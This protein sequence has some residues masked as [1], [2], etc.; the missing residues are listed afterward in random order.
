[1]NI[2]QKTSVLALTA[3]LLV[4]GWMALAPEEV[5]APRQPVTVI[6][7]SAPGFSVLAFGQPPAEAV[8]E[9]PQGTA[10]A[11]PAQATAPAPTPSRP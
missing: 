11:A 8:D 2:V 6:P 9:A 7:S 10:A 3:P 4:A 1:M 5:E